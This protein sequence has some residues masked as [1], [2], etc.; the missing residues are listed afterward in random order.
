MSLIKFG[1][2]EGWPDDVREV[3]HH[4]EGVYAWEQTTGPVRLCIAPSKDH[5]AL[6]ADLEAV[7]APRSPTWLLYVL[8]VQRG[9][10]EQGRYQSP[11]PIDYP[12]LLAFLARHREFLERD[13]RHAL[14][15]TAEDGLGAGQLVYDRHNVIFA[16][17]PLEPFEDVLQ[18]HG[19]RR[20]EAVTYPVPHA[21]YYHA[22]YDAAQERLL[23]E[24]PWLWSEL[25]A[26]DD[27]FSDD[28]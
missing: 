27:D 13:G 12:E 24:M 1:R 26:Q 15:M 19:L 21:H 4:Y 9:G 11:E 6:L 8:T 17:G 18:R 23:A 2:V 3:E 28:S 14:W 22:E 10:A 25:R 16:Y 20:V 5:V 7:W